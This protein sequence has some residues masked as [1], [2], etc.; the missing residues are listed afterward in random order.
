MV[1]E[2]DGDHG[3]LFGDRT[4]GGTQGYVRQGFDRRREF[5][6]MNLTGTSGKA[7]AAGQSTEKGARQ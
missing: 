3:G 7:E 1:V 5:S 6:S 4:V 2:G